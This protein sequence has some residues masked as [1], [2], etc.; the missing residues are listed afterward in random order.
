MSTLSFNFSTTTSAC[1]GTSPL[2]IVFDTTSLAV[3]GLF[4]AKIIYEFPDKTV[5]RDFTMVSD[6]A[7]LLPPYNQIDSRAPL[8]YTFDGADIA[9]DGSTTRVVNISAYVGPTQD[10]TVYTLSA[11]ILQQFLTKNPTGSSAPY[12]FE[13]VHLLKTRVWGPGN[14]QLFVLETKNPNYVLLNF[15]GGNEIP[16]VI[17]VTE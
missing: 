12:T 1:T 17:P 9:D 16:S 4:V 8:S 3:T 2:T 6:A 7:A 13:E 5:R 15:N 11:T 10:L 14:S